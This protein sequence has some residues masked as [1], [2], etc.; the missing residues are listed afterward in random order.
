MNRAGFPA[1]SSARAGA[2]EDEDAN[3]AQIPRMEIYQLAPFSSWRAA[4]T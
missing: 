1:G 3:E 2:K 4:S